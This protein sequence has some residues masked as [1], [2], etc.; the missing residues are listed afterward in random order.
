[1]P[2]FRDELD[3]EPDPFLLENQSGLSDG[4]R[5]ENAKWLY[6]CGWFIDAFHIIHAIAKSIPDEEPQQQEDSPTFKEIRFGKTNE[7]GERAEGGPEG[8]PDAG[9]SD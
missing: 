8:V 5:M 4:E 3:K 2:F 6:N 7:E 1:M 9:H